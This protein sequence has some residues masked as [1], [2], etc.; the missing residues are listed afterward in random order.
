MQGTQRA[1]K[2]TTA[3]QEQ[4]TATKSVGFTG[5]GDV[6]FPIA[7]ITVVNDVDFLSLPDSVKLCCVRFDYC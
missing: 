6:G 4:V 2:A 5:F 7:K 1:D 3:Q